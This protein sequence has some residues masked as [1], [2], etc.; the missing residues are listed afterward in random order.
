MIHLI[1]ANEIEMKISEWVLRKIFLMGID[2]A[3]TFASS[4]FSMGMEM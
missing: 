4:F 2:L 3:F 1:L